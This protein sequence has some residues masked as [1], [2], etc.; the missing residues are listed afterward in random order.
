MKRPNRDNL[1]PLGL[2]NY[3]DWVKY[4]NDLDDYCNKVEGENNGIK[5]QARA[6]QDAVNE[7]QFQLKEREA[8]L[9]WAFE[10][11]DMD[12]VEDYDTYDKLN[13]FL[14]NLKN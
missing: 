3:I 8:M 11:I 14:L 13:Q 6:L 7:L 2:Q 4:A 9:K 12:E 10:Q 5:V 1:D